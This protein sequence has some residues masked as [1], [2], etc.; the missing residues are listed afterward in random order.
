MPRYDYKCPIC[1]AVAEID[2]PMVYSERPVCDNCGLAEMRRLYSMPAVNWGGMA[3]S[4]GEMHPHTKQLINDAP[5]RRDNETPHQSN[6]LAEI[7]R[8]LQNG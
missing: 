8:R 3:P 6:R 4:Q 2:H 5:K 1:D 7:N